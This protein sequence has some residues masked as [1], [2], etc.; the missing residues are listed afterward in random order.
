M[1]PVYHII[2]KRTLLSVLHANPHSSSS[3]T[4][5]RSDVLIHPKN[6]CRAVF[7]LDL[8]QATIVHAIGIANS[9]GILFA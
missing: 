3:Y 6:V 5:Y 8:N 9:A 1:E 4:D 7:P 2:A